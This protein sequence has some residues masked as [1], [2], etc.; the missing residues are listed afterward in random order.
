M[1]LFQ[2]ADFIHSVPRSI[3]SAAEAGHDW[4]PP[5][6]RCVSLWDS[7]CVCVSVCACVYIWVCSRTPTRFHSPS[8][9]FSATHRPHVS[10]SSLFCHTPGKKLDGREKKKVFT[11]GSVLCAQRVN[12]NVTSATLPCCDEYQ[13]KKEM[14]QRG[15]D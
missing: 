15:T 1:A 8:S 7:L 12:R 9:G 6:H 3:W 5:G 10:P 4:H 14:R 2:T 11:I 13:L